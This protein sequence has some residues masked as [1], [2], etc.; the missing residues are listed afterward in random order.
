MKQ[1]SDT[2]WFI[3][4]KIVLAALTIMDFKGA[5]IEVENQGMKW[6]KL[7]RREMAIAKSRDVVVEI[8]G[9]G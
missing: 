9:R 8:E 5:R 3:F 7:T 4:I 2:I 6:L 1:E